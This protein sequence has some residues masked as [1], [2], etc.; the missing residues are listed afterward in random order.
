[1]RQVDTTEGTV[2]L[3]NYPH[4]TFTLLLLFP[5]FVL[6]P[7]PPPP[8][9]RW[10]LLPQPPHLTD[11]LL[12]PFVHI[13][14]RTRINRHPAH[15]HDIPEKEEEIEEDNESKEGK[16][17]TRKEMRKEMRKK[18]RN[19]EGGDNKRRASIVSVVEN[20]G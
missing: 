14:T 6:L 4:Y 8:N 20:S 12:L 5:F 18:T 19:N 16:K 17:K 15:L 11:T 1:M 10:C 7:P 9:V 2:V 3:Y 13:T